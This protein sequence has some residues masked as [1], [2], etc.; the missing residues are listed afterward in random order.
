MQKDDFSAGS[1][2]AA[3]LL[4]LSVV[5]ANVAGPSLLAQ[6]IHIKVLNARNGKPVARA[7][8]SVYFGTWHART[9]IWAATNQDG[10]AVIHLANGA[11]VAEAGCRALK[12]ASYFPTGVDTIAIRN[13]YH[14]DC[15]ELGPGFDGPGKY[16]PIAARHPTYSIRRILE[17][18]I[19]ASNICGKAR[20]QAKPGEL[21]VFA[22]SASLLEKLRE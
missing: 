12:R 1:L 10:I 17:S 9:D 20:A 18:G 15:Q 3:P 19:T 22:R 21:V 2:F 7:C 8:L 6:E 16:V 4:L 5:F 14:V 13:D 11:M